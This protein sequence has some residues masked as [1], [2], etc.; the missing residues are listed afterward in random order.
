[1]IEIRTLGRTS[2][3]VD[4][5]ELTGEA[6]WP[7]SLALIVYMAREPGP[8]RRDKILGMLWP[9]REEKRARHALN[10]LLYTLRKSSPQLDLES[11]E[12][13]LD[14]GT[15]VWLDVE[16]F[17]RRLEKGDLEG[18]V[19]LYD[20]PFLVDLS[21]EVLDFDHWTDRQRTQLT[22][23][24]RKAALQLAGQAKES[25]QHEAAIAYCR[26]LLNA[27]PL[28]DEV[29]HLLIECLYL[30]GE[31]VPALRQFEKYR[32]LLAQELEVEPL[33]STLELV[34]RI[35]SEPSGP[36]AVPAA[37]P[38]AAGEPVPAAA[39]ARKGSAARFV[40][41]SRSLFSAGAVLVVAA[42]TIL[43]IWLWPEQ[44]VFSAAGGALD[45]VVAAEARE[46]AV[47]PF[48]IETSGTSTT[49][50]GPALAELLSVNLDGLGAIRTLDYRTVLQ[51]WEGSRLSRQNIQASADLAEFARSLGATALLTGSVHANGD[52][53]RIVADL[54]STATGE[55]LTRA[56]V[57]GPRDE[58]FDLTDRV[59]LELLAGVWTATDIPAP[60]AA[61]TGTSSLTAL[62]HYLRAEL[63]YRRAEWDE[64]GA[65]YRSAVRED[66][67]FLPA[68]RSLAET[69]LWAA[70]EHRPE[71]VQL[72]ERARRLAIEHAAPARDLE[73]DQARSHFTMGNGTEAIR[74]FER[75]AERYPE[76]FSIRYQVADA[77]F[78]YGPRIMA[79]LEGVS[80]RLE[81]L[82]ERDSSFAPAIDHLWWTAMWRGDAEAA[83]KW[84]A[85]YTEAAPEGTR[86][87][88]APIAT[89][90]AFDGA[91]ERGRALARLS[92]LS[93]DG[94]A[95][96][97]LAVALPVNADPKRTRAIA[98]QLAADEGSMAHR[99]V[100]AE[101]LAALE[102]ASG[103]PEAAKEWLNSAQR[104]R[105]SRDEVGAQAAVAAVYGLTEDSQP[106]YAM[107]SRPAPEAEVPRTWVRD[108]W[109]SGAL[110]LRRGDSAGLARSLR[111]LAEIPETTP[112]G[113]LA[114]SLAAGLRGEAALA[115]RDTAAAL[116][117]LRLASERYPELAPLSRWQTLP[118][119]RFRLGEL[120]AA[121]GDGAAAIA[122]FRSLEDRSFGDMLLKPR[123]YLALARSLEAEGSSEEAA[124]YYAAAARWWE[125]AEAL[126]ADDLA[127]ARAGASR[128]SGTR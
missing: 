117:E 17:E 121:A 12:D 4:G 82:L 22:R 64:A 68:T 1:M 23:K 50:S 51:A 72:F 126:F 2:I 5:T 7:K 93:S 25:G 109:L 56:D 78:H 88:M 29:Q 107:P 40:A 28:D 105:L 18:A 80:N 124:R 118:Y 79:S 36:I 30:S 108:V 125:D 42:V 35:R 59:T 66:S 97:F 43:A 81:A 60:R 71:A 112:N 62:K 110:A 95:L 45:G 63:H 11:I 8:D 83:R 39:E 53:M 115:A 103:R 69:I 24:F 21:V 113:A 111:A 77:Y 106:D 76:D 100:G 33:D 48:R 104:L 84:A 27:D 99:A 92:A 6:A 114:H 58:F 128:L 44:N 85:A 26:R 20:G 49:E 87:E 47:L 67:M 3:S 10:Q 120:E 46:I 54:V 16:E 9:D 37:R 52:E 55:L 34:D 101:L 32:V 123:M 86:S 31:R 19:A 94:A 61:A 119:Y 96:A 41:N 73:F 90:I 70:Q 89:A 65:A 122:A 98:G 15:D 14:F 75:L 74:G 13:A 38:T 116:R 127:A 102:F 91:D 57:R